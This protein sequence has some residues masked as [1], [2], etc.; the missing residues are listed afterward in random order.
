MAIANRYSI[1]IDTFYSV[2]ARN[3]V[4]SKPQFTGALFY[5]GLSLTL[6]GVDSTTALQKRATSSHYVKRN[7]RGAFSVEVV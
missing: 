4:T 3:V 7:F 1:G 5:Y 6:Q 2:V